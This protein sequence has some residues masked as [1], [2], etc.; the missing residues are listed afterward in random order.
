M[1]RVASRNATT[2]SRYGS[3]VHK[4]LYIYGGLDVS[5]T[6]LTRGYG[7]AWGIGGWLV[8]AYLQKLGA[9]DVQRLRDRVAAELKTTFASR[10]AAEITLAEALSPTAIATYAKR[11]TG[12]K[13]LITPC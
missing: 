7:M 10:Y 6:L 12:E 4:Q 3:S 5:P 2:Y 9:R 1:E 11:A 8:F 13:Y